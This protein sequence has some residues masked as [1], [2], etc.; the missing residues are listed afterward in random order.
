[1]PTE[2]VVSIAILAVFCT[3]VAFVLFGAL[4]ADVGPSRASV[5]TY[6]APV[7]ALVLGVVAL[8][9][10]LG[11]GAILGFILILIGSYFATSGQLSDTA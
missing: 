7:V 2:A 1:M 10:S 6:V 3:A 9:E 5:I 11:A 4:V 8:D